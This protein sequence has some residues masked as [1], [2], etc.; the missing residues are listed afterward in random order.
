MNI[1]DLLDQLGI[2][3]R[4]LGEHHHATS[5]YDA[6]ID[7]PFCSPGSQRFRMGVNSSWAACW[8]C[9]HKPLW[10]TI[11]EAAGKS[12]RQIPELRDLQQHTEVRQQHRG[13]LKLPKGLG[14]LMQPH[15]WYLNR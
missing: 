10:E 7:C 11:A 6:Q 2:E 5:K 14:P 3:Y 4:V 8:I 1:I 15:K 13:T 12:V 9:G